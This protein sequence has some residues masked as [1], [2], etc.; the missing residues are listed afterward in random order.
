MNTKV[1]IAVT[2][3]LIGAFSV[4]TGLVVHHNDRTA[5]A[6]AMMVSNTM[7]KTAIMKAETSAAMKQKQSDEM[8]AHD[9]MMNSSSSSDS[10]DSS[11]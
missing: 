7:E 9:S 8:V 11:N 3:V 10:M 4:G 1:M 6:H 5:S 2:I